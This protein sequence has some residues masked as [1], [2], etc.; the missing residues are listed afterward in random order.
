M[1]NY[2]KILYYIFIAIYVPNFTLIYQYLDPQY[3]FSVCIWWH[4]IYQPLSPLGSEYGS[5]LIWLIP[6]NT[7]SLGQVS[8]KDGNYDS[9]PRARNSWK[10]TRS[11][12]GSEWSLSGV[13]KRWKMEIAETLHCKSRP[14][15]I[16]QS[17]KEKSQEFEVGWINKQVSPWPLE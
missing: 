4:H 14:P 12:P 5:K 3:L 7:S 1:F 10:K 2:Y 17:M 16:A 8:M 6:T 11:I 15:Q 9:Y 13:I